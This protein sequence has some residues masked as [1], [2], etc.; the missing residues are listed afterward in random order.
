LLPEVPLFVF[1]AGIGLQIGPDVRGG[2]AMTRYQTLTI[3]ALAIAAGAIVQS[4]ETSPL[5]GAAQST[6]Q[7]ERLS[8][9]QVD[10]GRE[11]DIKIDSFLGRQALWL[12]NNTHARRHGLILVDGTIEL[13]VAPMDDGDFIGLTFRRESQSNHE[14]IYIRPPRSGEFMAIQYA[15]R[16]NGSSTWQLYREFNAPTRWRRNQW[17]HVRL[18]IHG[19]QLDV[20]VGE[21]TKPTLSVPRL[22]HASPSGEVGFWARVNNRPS[23]WAAALSNISIRPAATS[24][25]RLEP[26]PPQAGVVTSWQVAGPVPAVSRPIDSLPQ[27]LNWTP[28]ACEESGLV[29][30]NRLFPAKPQQGRFTAFLRTT[31]TAAAARRVLAGIGY[32]DDVT[33]FVN[34]EPLYSG[35]NG[36]ESRAPGFAS[37]VD[38]R[39]E[40]IWLPLHAGMNEIVLAVTDDQLF[41]WGASMSM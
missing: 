40:R 3:L 23:E 2:A 27:G 19:S 33:V 10:P 26:A 12:R 7:G 28:V 18:E 9:W 4:I 14:N 37:F 36:W 24:M 6:P 41:G 17:T 35:V 29:N 31:L 15:P 32:S 21:T 34:G 16:I 22:R 38:P 13:D 30:L 8:D 39:F 11:S 20:F 1:V 25:G 5:I